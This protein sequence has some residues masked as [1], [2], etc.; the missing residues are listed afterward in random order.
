MK[1]WDDDMRKR[2]IIENGSIQNIDSI[3]DD[4]KNVYKT[5][6]ELKQMHLVEQSTD[7]GIFIDQSQSFNLFMPEPNFD[8]LTSALINGH[9]GKK[10]QTKTSFWEGRTRYFFSV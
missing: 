9:E 6:F 2:L 10:I 7:R 1:L 4:I 3:P 5:A 8:V